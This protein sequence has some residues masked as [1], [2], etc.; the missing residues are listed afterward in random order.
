MPTIIIYKPLTASCVYFS[1]RFQMQIFAQILVETKSIQQHHHRLTQRIFGYILTCIFSST[2]LCSHLHGCMFGYHLAF[3]YS[4]LPHLLCPDLKFIARTV[5]VSSGLGVATVLFVSYVFCYMLCSVVNG[6]LPSF[7][8][9]LRVQRTSTA[10]F[11]KLPQLE[12]RAVGQLGITL[13]PVSNLLYVNL[14][15]PVLLFFSPPSHCFS[16]IFLGRC[17]APWARLSA[18]QQVGWRKY[19]GEYDDNKLRVIVTE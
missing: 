10:F 7:P 19:L 8:E 6:C 1:T 13:T 17:F 9:A 15:H 18:H 3:T 14:H 16:R 11:F 2:S 12:Q 4:S 5:M